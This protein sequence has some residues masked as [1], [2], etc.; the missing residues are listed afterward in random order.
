MVVDENNGFKV[1]DIHDT[2]KEANTLCK[3]YNISIVS[4]FM[5]TKYI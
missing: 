1:N 2:I 4:R 5:L 3:L